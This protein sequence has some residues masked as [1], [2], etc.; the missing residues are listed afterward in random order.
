[1][2]KF[3]FHRLLERLPRWL[4]HIYALFF[5][6]VGWVI[7][8]FEDFGQLGS[9]LA[10]LFGGQG[11]AS[12]WDTIVL[13]LRYLPLLLI[14][15]VASTP[16]GARLMARVR[17]SRAG[18]VITAALCLASLFLCTCALVDQSYNPFLYF[19]F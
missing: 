3:V 7:F 8:Y 17:T 5:I 16:L 18:G 4:R 13:L 1:M 19:R 12:S 9:Y 14:A 15:A 10:A 11:L 2:E 6:V